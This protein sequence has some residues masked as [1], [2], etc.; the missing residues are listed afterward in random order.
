MGTQVK[1]TSANTPCLPNCVA[2]GGFHWR[3]HLPGTRQC[4]SVLRLTPANQG[5]VGAWFVPLHVRN[6]TVASILIEPS[7]I[8]SLYKWRNNSVFHE[9]TVTHFQ[10]GGSGADPVFTF[11]TIGPALFW[12]WPHVYFHFSFVT[13]PGLTSNFD[14]LQHQWRSQWEMLG[15][16]QIRLSWI[17]LHTWAPL[18]LLVVGIIF[19]WT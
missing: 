18:S 5:C 19:C 17:F 2:P 13:K 14:Q 15:C 3:P 10:T 12:D 9:N 7:F 6:R 8:W 11:F 4:N 1:T 16:Y